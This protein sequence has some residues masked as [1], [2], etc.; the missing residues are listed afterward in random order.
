MSAMNV[1]GLY[2]GIDMSTVEQLIQAESSRGVKFTKQKETYQK[3]QTAWKDVNSR[4]DNLYKKFEVLKNPETFNSKTVKTSNEGFVSVSSTSNADTGEYKLKVSQLATATRL[5]G[6]Q[7]DLG[8][9]SEDSK[10]TINNGESDFEFDIT[11]EMDLKDIKNLI[12]ETS[13][14]SKV[15]ASIVDN[16]LILTRSDLGNKTLSVDGDA[17][18]ALGFKSSE[19]VSVEA[20]KGQSAILFIDGL[21]ITK[22]SNTIDDVIE[23]VTFKLQNV[24]EDNKSDTLT[25]S[26]NTEKAATAMKELVDQYNSLNSFIKQQTSVG[27]PSA[28][29]NVTGTLVGDSSIARLQTNLRSMFT[30]NIE[31]ASGSVNNLQDLGVQIDRNGTATFNSDKLIKKLEED[32]D[33]VVN[34][35]HSS[36]QVEDESGSKTTKL[37]GFANAARSLVN[38]YISST[39]GIIK[40]KSETYDRLIKDVNQRIETFNKRIET[41]RE[42][43][44]KQ[45]TAL[46]TAMMQAESQIQFMMGQL[47]GNDK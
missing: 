12:N 11:T 38:E 2:S 23:G 31:T 26:D 27:D 25:I 5:T 41:K 15:K 28:E 4:L 14:D 44:I 34:F 8:L 33:G 30:R 32:P 36:E 18:Q 24:H 3:Q 10:L 21:E 1:M 35:F 45:F 42:Q 19:L 16:R 40:T 47:G 6:T 37:S 9:L 20:V 29:N 22:D 43:Y 7:A 17:V 46:D 13:S 39:T